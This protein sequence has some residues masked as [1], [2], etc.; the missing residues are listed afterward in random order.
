MIDNREDFKL[1]RERYS[2]RF[3]NFGYSEKAVGWGDKGRQRLRYEVLLSYWGPCDG[4]SIVDLGAG[5]GDGCKPFFDCGG[6]HYLGLEFLTEF[7]EIGKKQFINYGEKFEL[8]QSNIGELEIFPEADL[9][10]GSGLFNSKFK[11]SDNYEFI[12]E[13]LFKAFS[14]CKKGISFNFLSDKTDYKE[15]YIFYSDL[16]KISNIVEKLSRNFCIKKDYF[17]FEFSIYINKNES[18]NK[19]T[20]TFNNP[21]FK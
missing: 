10:I 7:V 3:L 6:G 9:I 13:T 20:S 8:C 14:A 4:L 17:P 2:T 1:M 16:T 19:E 11:S 12:E 18:F 15:Q 5:F 21:K